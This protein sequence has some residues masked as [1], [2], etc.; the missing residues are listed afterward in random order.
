[1][2]TYIN[3]AVND[4]LQRLSTVKANIKDS[5]KAKALL[6]EATRV[7]ESTNKR[8]VHF[9]FN[10]H[11]RVKQTPFIK[12]LTLMLSG[13][14]EQHEVEEHEKFEA[15]I[16]KFIEE[17]LEDGEHNPVTFETNEYYD[18]AL[19][20]IDYVSFAVANNPFFKLDNEKYFPEAIVINA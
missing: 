16:E 15:Y 4:E 10:P 17:T 18:L 13:D 3:S 19:H 8:I 2:E 12:K 9:I 20:G 6:R 14:L 1:V 7:I 5:M 11:Q